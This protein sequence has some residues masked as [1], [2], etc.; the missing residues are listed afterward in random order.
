AQLTGPRVG[1]K[2]LRGQ[3]SPAIGFQDLVIEVLDAQAQ[4]SNAESLQCFQL[5][6]LQCAGLAL[7]RHLLRVFPGEQRL[8]LFEQPAQL[9]SAEEGGRAA[10]EVD[11]MEGPA[12]RHGHGGV[13]SDFAHECVEIDID[14]AGVLVGVDA[15]IA[16]F[17]AFAAKRNVQI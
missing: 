1:A 13:E 10:A 9:V 14:V 11:E 16:K 3:V 15:E 5:V 17:A 12:R 7:K 4:P 2:N 8:Y 6:L